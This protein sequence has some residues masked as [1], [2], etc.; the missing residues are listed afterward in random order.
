MDGFN[1]DE[2]TCVCEEGNYI[3]E[4]ECLPCQTL[5]QSC[6]DGASC[7]SCIQNAVNGESSC[8]CSIGYYQDN[9]TCSACPVGCETCENESVCN[10]CK[11][12]FEISGTVCACPEEGFFEI[13]NS[14]NECSHMCRTCSDENTCIELAVIVYSY[15]CQ[16]TKTEDQCLTESDISVCEG[17]KSCEVSELS[18]TSTGKCVDSLSSDNS[19]SENYLARYRECSFRDF[20][21][22]GYYCNT[23]ESLCLAKAEAYNSCTD[24]YG[25]EKGYVCN[26]GVCI[27]F[28]SLETNWY[29]ESSVACKSG[30]VANNICQP[31]EITNCDSGECIGIGEYMAKICLSD[32]DCFSTD[33]N[34]NT[35]CLAVYS[36]TGAAYCEPHRSDKIRKDQLTAIYNGE[37][38]S[39]RLKSY[40][41][42]HYIQIRSVE[43]ENTKDRW[44]FERLKVYTD[45]FKLETIAKECFSALIS[46]G[47]SLILAF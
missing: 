23:T 5:C 26:L 35:S 15:K 2:G 42:I 21:E 13:D 16:E 36:G 22:P 39:F 27:K 41:Y 7:K 9:S 40:E 24:L 31:N 12:N 8:T 45:Y 44:C 6:S 29:S 43:N 17:G 14:C 20:C 30:I 1:V 37:Y 18:S 10:T 33:G 3:D 38:E 34:S 11:D 4:N 32:F 46:L 25:C 19:C 28:F 47:L